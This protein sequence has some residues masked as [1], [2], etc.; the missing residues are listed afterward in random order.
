MVDGKLTGTEVALVGNL[1]PE[2]AEECR[3]LV[4]S[5]EVSGMK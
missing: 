4:M 5:M 3:A 1:M 2:S